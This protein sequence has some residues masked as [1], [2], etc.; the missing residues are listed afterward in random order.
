M[1][2]FTLKNNILAEL[3]QLEA[4]SL[5]NRKGK[6]TFWKTIVVENYRFGQQL[7]QERMRKFHAF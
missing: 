6:Y 2:F 4:N 3:I 7:F 1:K 5:L